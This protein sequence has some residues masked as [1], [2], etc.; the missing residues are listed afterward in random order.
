MRLHRITLRDVRGVSE[1]TVELPDSGVVVVEGP[2]EIGKSTLLEAFDRV[3]D[4]KATSKS[5]RAQ[6]LQP[7]GRDVGPFV[8]AEFTLAGRRVR[9]A[10]RWLRSPMTELEI[11]GAR[12]E[13]LTGAAAQARLEQLVGALDS[14]LWEALRLTQSDDGSLV[15]LV[16]SGTL[17]EALDAA[18]DAQ[19]HDGDGEQVLD[20]VEEEYLRYFTAR[21]GRPTGDYKAAIEAHTAAQADV[22]EGHRRL[23]E[24]E[25]LLARQ[26]DARADEERLTEAVRTA[27]DRSATARERAAEVADLVAEHERAVARLGEA[28]E[29]AA[30]ARRRWEER[31]ARV[32]ALEALAATVAEHEEHVATLAEQGTQVRARLEEAERSHRESDDE[33]E[34]AELRLDELRRDLEL[35]ERQEELASLDRVLAEV[36][37][38]AAVLREAG[39]EAPERPVTEEQR[40]RVDDLRQQVEV[41]EAQRAAASAT[42]RVESLGESV[43]VDLVGDAHSDGDGG[44]EAASTSS[45]ASTVAVGTSAE[46]VATDDVVV[47]VPGA[48]RLVVRSPDGDGRREALVQARAALAQALSDLACADVQ[49][50]EQQAALTR[51]AL[52]RR[53]EA[54]RDLEALLQAHGVTAA[55]DRADVVDGRPPRSLLARR[56]SCAEAVADLAARAEL[57]DP[58]ELTAGED[59][60]FSRRAAV[61]REQVRAAEREASAELRAVRES[62]RAAAASFAA[63]RDEARRLASAL[64]RL[65]G[66]LGSERSQHERDAEALRVDREHAG[67]D[68]LAEQLAQHETALAQTEAEAQRAGAVMAEA[69][70]PGLTTA[71]RDADAELAAARRALE[72]A[73][74]VLHSLTG[75]VELAASEGRQELYDLAEADLDD[76]ERRLA[77]LDRRARAVRHLRT[78][79]H[80][81]RDAAHRAYVR[82]FTDALE[83]L[84]RRVYGDSFAVTVDE[85]LSVRARTLDGT[86]VPF[87]ELS[88]GAKEQL[89]I[90][91]RLAV[92]HLVDPTQGVPVVIDDALGYSDPQR[93]AQMGRVIARGAGPEDGDGDVQV[94][95]LT[96]TPQR[97]AAIP[98]AHTVR[99]EAS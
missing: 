38:R 26:A 98:S 29:R 63:A 13:H 47:T 82:P 71:V 41:L 16:S 27:G 8:E 97:Y 74:Q 62:R 6:A 24:A 34:R 23:V 79:L 78:A 61:E 22:A 5:A 37:R 66:Q 36:E 91:A 7:I 21:T 18:A 31:T 39:A 4:L 1:R 15:P 88:G 12:P 60:S 46:V 33:V 87:D 95:L 14:T 55:Q 57:P 84:G 25:S 40:H 90:L 53:R 68:A 2:N 67:D 17:R 32:A 35:L 45:P 73:R 92:A 49:E 77:A 30:S 11:L 83:R 50:V 89:G 43:Q 69:D 48:V 58:G 54:T 59:E 96:C 81:H 44:T 75:Q 3:L 19:L 93:L 51:D 20:L 56:R 52:S 64:D 99:L 42:V 72:G 85:Q 10:K 80:E 86:T 28:R 9:L 76:A 94:I 65:D 70:V